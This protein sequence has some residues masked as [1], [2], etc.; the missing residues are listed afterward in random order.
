MDFPA[1]V[2]ENGL[3]GELR[4]LGHA[5]GNLGAVTAFQTLE[6]ISAAHRK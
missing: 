6:E 4:P 1:L 5:A 2:T 3:N